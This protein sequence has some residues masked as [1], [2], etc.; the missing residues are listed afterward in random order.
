MEAV[1]PGPPPH[2][3]SRP[4]LVAGASG[5][6]GAALT[7]GGLRFGRMAVGPTAVPASPA[8]G[9]GGGGLLFI[10][11]D[12]VADYTAVPPEL[13]FPIL[14]GKRNRQAVDPSIGKDQALGGPMLYGDDLRW[15]RLWDSACHGVSDSGGSPDTPI[16]F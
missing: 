13:D 7:E 14:Q 16:P 4:V 15:L 6:F 10:P 5:R 3:T 11:S 2:R 12:F 9:H 8:H 1:Q